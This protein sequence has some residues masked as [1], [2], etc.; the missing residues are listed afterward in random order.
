MHSC[1]K[2]A[3]FT[4]FL[5]WIIFHY[6]MVLEK[7][8]GRPTENVGVLSSDSRASS[9]GAG[10]AGQCWGQRWAE[11]RLQGPVACCVLCNNWGKHT[12]R[13]PWPALRAG[14]AVRALVAVGALAVGVYLPDCW[15]LYGHIAAEARDGAGTGCTGTQLVGLASDR[16]HAAGQWQKM[17]WWNLPGIPGGC[18]ALYFFSGQSCYGWLQG[19]SLGPQSLPLADTSAPLFFPVPG[20]LYVSKLCQSLGGVKP[21]G[22]LHEVP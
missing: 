10:Q 14:P 20:S 22:L 16:S 18:V 19:M 3:E 4:S 12:V 17:A 5:W 6:I 2:M 9:S 21:N 8:C 7:C 13:G 11:A 15:S 1:W